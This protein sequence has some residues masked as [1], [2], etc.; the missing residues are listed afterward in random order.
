LLFDSSTILSERYP[1]TTSPDSSPQR[2]QTWDREYET[3]KLGEHLAL[4]YF[5][6]DATDPDKLAALTSAY[7][8]YSAGLTPP[9]ELPDLADVFPDDPHVRAEIG[10][11][12]EPDATP[13]EALVQA[14]GACHNDVLDQGISRARFNIA[15]SRLDPAEVA[16][17]IDRL[18][19]ARSEPG[20]M[21]P[22]EARQLDPRVRSQLIEYLQAGN[23]SAPD[24]D[25]LAHAASA[26]MAGNAEPDTR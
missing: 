3:F 1:L 8:S 17:A 22:P 20:A 12:T 9:A 21:P 2:S 24:L 19:I 23:F 13:A 4:P 14:C 10:L 25:M 6:R 26:G 18:D 16:V 5:D 15:L 7:Q 11:Q